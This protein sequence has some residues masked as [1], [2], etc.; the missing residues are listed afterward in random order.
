MH[1]SWPLSLF[2]CVSV[3]SCDRSPRST[4]VQ[5]LTAGQPASCSQ[6]LL[7]ARE[8]MGAEDKLSLFR[9]VVA[10]CPDSSMADFAQ[11]MV[12][13]ILLE[14]LDK[15]Q[16]AE[17]AFKILREKYPQSPWIQTADSLRA[18]VKGG[19]SPPP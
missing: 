15:P 4:F 5:D 17:E 1:R 14:E 13:F 3:L 19:G 8:A 9:Q 2:L 18:G 10:S 7:R 6:L 12:G 16:E 11:F